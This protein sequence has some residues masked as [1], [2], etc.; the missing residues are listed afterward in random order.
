MVRGWNDER[1]GGGLVFRGRHGTETTR[2]HIMYIISE[3]P[4]SRTDMVGKRWED[5]A[6]KGLET[7]GVTN[8]IQNL[9]GSLQSNTL[10]TYKRV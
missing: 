8:Q 3:S 10:P 7:M 9:A 5:F 1:S 2:H 6:T 4:A